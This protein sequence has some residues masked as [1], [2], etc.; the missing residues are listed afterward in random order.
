MACAPPSSWCRSPRSWR[1]RGRDG[2]GGLAAFWGDQTSE[3]LW[4]DLAGFLDQLWDDLAGWLDS[5][6]QADALACQ[7]IHGVDV[8]AGVTVRW[9]PHEA[10]HRHGLPADD[11]LA[12]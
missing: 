12:D 8:T 9:E 2:A 5:P 7:Q 6:G 4:G 1:T 3:A 11:G 10:Q